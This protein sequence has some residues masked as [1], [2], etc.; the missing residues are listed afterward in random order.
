MHI[1]FPVNLK[2]QQ[3]L[4]CVG[5]YPPPP[6]IHTLLAQLILD[7]SSGVELGKLLRTSLGAVTLLGFISDYLVWSL[8]YR[9]CQHQRCCLH[10]AWMDSFAPNPA[11]STSFP[12]RGSVCCCCCFSE[13]H[14]LA[15][16]PEALYQVILEAFTGPPL[17]SPGMPVC[18]THSP[19]SG[20]WSHQ[21]QSSWRLVREPDRR[22]TGPRSLGRCCRWQVC[23]VEAI[24]AAGGV[25]SKAWILLKGSLYCQKVLASLRKRSNVCSS[26]YSQIKCCFPLPE[27][28]VLV[29]VS[30]AVMQHHDQK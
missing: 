27:V 11:A 12:L 25:G 23:H 28:V 18:E 14:S 17:Q 22:T 20:K 4:F 8:L 21:E 9:T 30:V 1:V 6:H 19:A 10:L 3:Y 13:I 7:L 2:S 16:L 5:V 15:M 26:S 24:S 29:V